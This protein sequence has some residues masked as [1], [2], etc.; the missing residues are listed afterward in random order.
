MEK[1]YIWTLPTRAFHILLAISVLIAFLTGDE[2]S[3]LNYHAIVGYGIGILLFYRFVWGYVGPKYSKF[4]DFP[5]GKK[6]V[7]EFLSNIFEANQ[8]YVGHNPLASYVML[9]M[10]GTLFLAF[11]TGIL[12][13]G[14]QEGKG[15][16]G[17]LNSSYFKEMK[18]FKEIHEIFANLFLGLLFLH[19]S[20][21]AIDRLLHK[22]EQ[23]L[24]SIFTGYKNREQQ[25]SIKLNIFQKMFSLLIF[26]FFIAFLVYSLLEPKNILT[27][28]I[29]K[30]ID[31]KQENIAFVSE[32]GS[33]HTLYPPSLLP[34][35]SWEKI[36]QNL[37]DHFGDDASVDEKTN[38]SILSYLVKNSAETSTTEASLKFLNSI[39]N[40]DIIAMSQTS[41][42]KKTHK[43]IPKEIFDNPKIKS[44]SNCKACH[45]DVEKGFI[46]DENIKDFD[47]IK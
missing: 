16:L 12:A 29:Y 39:K 28:S 30:S 26:I 33:C 7:K 35:K 32:C 9:A 37:D 4:R 5:I 22:K 18:L 15:I 20:G 3:L 40:E 19:L 24:N 2:D 1:S 42:W 36:M 41:F 25:E 13:F 34:A 21:I 11:L 10:L 8:K 45:S 31:F 6:N 44:P 27:A 14:I 17:F 47:D 43:E 46:E 38:Q 23:N